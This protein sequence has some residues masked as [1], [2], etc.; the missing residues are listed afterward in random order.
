MF[1]I[2]ILIWYISI[3]KFKG[4]I[5]HG[6]YWRIHYNRDYFIRSYFNFDSWFKFRK[7]ILD[8]GFLSSII[9]IKQ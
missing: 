5:T 1:A 8:F 3:K 6:R 7:I 2:S 4:G 9:V